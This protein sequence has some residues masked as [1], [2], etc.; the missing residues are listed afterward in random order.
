MSISLHKLLVDRLERPA[1]F[2]C[3]SLPASY[4]DIQL[5]SFSLGL[6]VLTICN[7]NAITAKKSSLF[8]FCVN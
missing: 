1:S 4:G 2:F 3:F 8:I 5:P 6:R 7:L